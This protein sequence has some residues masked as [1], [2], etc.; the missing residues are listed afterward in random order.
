MKVGL[1]YWDDRWDHDR[2]RKGKERG[3]AILQEEWKR[4]RNTGKE[5]EKLV[6]W[7]IEKERKVK[8][9]KYYKSGGE[10]TKK[11][12]NGTKDETAKRRNLKKKNNKK[13][14]N[15]EVEMV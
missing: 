3:E 9:I 1:V 2:G 5:H 11:E 7:L 15:K 12:E 14:G 10:G 4:K 6:N 8:K 13:E